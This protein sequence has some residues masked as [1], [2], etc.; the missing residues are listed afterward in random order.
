MRSQ[1]VQRFQRAF[2]V[3]DE[4]ADAFEERGRGRPGGGG[5]AATSRAVARTAGS[6]SASRNTVLSLDVTRFWRAVISYASAEAGSPGDAARD[7]P[8]PMVDALRLRAMT[9]LNRGQMSLRPL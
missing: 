8:I 2:V 3:A 9:A 6:R 1:F 7:G 4:Y 5:E